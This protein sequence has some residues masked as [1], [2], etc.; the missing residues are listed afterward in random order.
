MQNTKNA[1]K[2]HFF[3]HPRREETHGNIDVVVDGSVNV[4]G[5]GIE[6]GRPAELDDAGEHAPERQ[7][8]HGR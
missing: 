1:S 5:K 2:R 3:A 7:K 4:V 8:K 6:S